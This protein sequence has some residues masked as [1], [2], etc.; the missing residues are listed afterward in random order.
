MTCDISLKKSML[1]E[2]KK[3]GSLAQTK[4]MT[5][6]D[7]TKNAFR[8]IEHAKEFFTS[9]GFEVKVHPLTEIRSEL[10]TP[11]VLGLKEEEVGRDL[12]WVVVEMKVK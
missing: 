8:D 5:G 7:V 4:K 6:M 1:A 11:K 2:D 3:M 12:S 9:L 10:V